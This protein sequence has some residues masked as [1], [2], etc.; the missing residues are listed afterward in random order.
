[1]SKSSDTTCEG[2]YK[3]LAAKVLSDSRK[4]A[5]AKAAISIGD[6]AKEAEGRGDGPIDALYDAILKISGMEGSLTEFIAK[7]LI[8]NGKASAVVDIVWQD[9][10]EKLWCGHGV[11]VDI[12]SSAGM[13]LIDVFNSV[14]D[15]N[16]GDREKNR[17]SFVDNL[18][19]KN[20]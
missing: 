15:K 12:I 18:I 3:F 10:N 20:D 11:H 4:G 8:E 16:V 2:K 13:A 6:V 9:E 19:K 7:A 1:M 5:R 17:Q 14:D